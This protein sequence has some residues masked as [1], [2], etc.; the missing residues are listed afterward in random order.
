VA[1]VDPVEVLEEVLELLLEAELEFEEVLV[2]LLEAE[3][4][5]EE[6]LV[7]DAVFE[8]DEVLVL[9]AVFEVDEVLVLDVD[10][11]V[12][13]LRTFT[14]ATVASSPIAHKSDP[15]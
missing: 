9:D 6:V 3:L 7:L 2:L 5:L 12:V 13:F 14:D 10:E 15:I 8:V 1:P 11:E 4:L